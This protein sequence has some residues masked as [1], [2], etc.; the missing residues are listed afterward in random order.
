MSVEAD[1]VL[2]KK[3]TRGG[4]F[5]WCP[6]KITRCWKL[7]APSTPTGYVFVGYFGAVK[8]CQCYGTKDSRKIFQQP[9]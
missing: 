7:K 2:A 6:A 8:V 4:R 9:V 3:E 5:S 1:L